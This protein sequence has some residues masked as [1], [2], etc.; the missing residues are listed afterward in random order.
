M[1]GDGVIDIRRVRAAVEA[2]GFGGYVEVEV[3]SHRWWSRPLDEVL[4]ICIERLKTA[5]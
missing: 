3:F 5:V 1:M 4:A 2:L